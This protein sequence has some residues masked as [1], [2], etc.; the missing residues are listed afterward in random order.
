PRRGGLRGPRRT[1]ALRRR[2]ALPPPACPALRP[3][4]LG[5]GRPRSGRAARRGARPERGAGP[6]AGVRLPRL[7]TPREVRPLRGNRRSSSMISR[8]TI[9]NPFNRG[10]YV[11]GAPTPSRWAKNTPVGEGAAALQNSPVEVPEAVVE[12]L[13]GAAEAVHTGREEVATRTR[14]WWAGSMIGDTAGHPATPDAVVVE[15]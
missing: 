13:R 10:N 15:A 1:G 4:R 11:Q 3:R 12:R 2:R 9:T 6:A 7:H 14:D 5:R 8:Q